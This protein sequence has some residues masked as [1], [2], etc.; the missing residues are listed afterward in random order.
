M[1]SERFIYFDVLDI[2]ALHTIKKQRKDEQDKNLKKQFVH[3]GTAVRH[4][5]NVLM[6]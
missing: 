5:S 2:K 4:R 1:H 6:L 3:D